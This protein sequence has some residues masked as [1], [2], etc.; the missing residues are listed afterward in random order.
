M[1]ESVNNLKGEYGFILFIYGLFNYAFSIKII[2][3]RMRG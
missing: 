1:N 2:W 3:S